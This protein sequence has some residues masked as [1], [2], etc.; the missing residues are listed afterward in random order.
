MTNNHPCTIADLLP[1]KFEQMQPLVDAQMAADAELSQKRW[2]GFVRRMIAARATQ[3]VLQSLNKSVLL[4]LP[5]A[6][7]RAPEL[8]EYADPEKHPKDS[9]TTLYL[10]EHKFEIDYKPIVNVRILNMTRPFLK[11]KLILASQVRGASIK[12]RNG[13]IVSIGECDFAI[14]AELKHVL[15]ETTNPPK[16]SPFHFKLKSRDIKLAEAFE[17]DS[18]GVPIV[19]AKQPASTGQ[20]L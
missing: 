16:E 3:A 15:D 7:S 17:L 20:V 8:A 11:L 9:E 4:I 6:W 1:Q 13:H 2:P 10:G 5:A 18:P 19:R 14:E 12:I